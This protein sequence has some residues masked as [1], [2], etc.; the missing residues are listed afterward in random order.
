VVVAAEPDAHAKVARYAVKPPGH[1]DDADQVQDED[2]DKR[3]GH[4]PD[5]GESAGLR[6][7]AGFVT[8]TRERENGLLSNSAGPDR[9]VENP[10]NPATPHDEQQPSG[11]CP[12]C[13]RPLALPS[14]SCSMRQYHGGA[15]P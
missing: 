6:G 10:Y 2:P 4:A 7:F 9:P 11:P 15:A 5:D 12:L 14:Q 13:D 3:P 8:A 1:A